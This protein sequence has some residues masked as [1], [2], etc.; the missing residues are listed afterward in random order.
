MKMSSKP[1]IFIFP[2]HIP[3]V[4]T[5]LQHYL[6]ETPN[7][8]GHTLNHCGYEVFRT[9]FLLAT[10]MILLAAILSFKSSTKRLHTTSGIICKRDSSEVKEIGQNTKLPENRLF[11]DAQ[12]HPLERSVYNRTST[13][14]RQHRPLHR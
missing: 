1:L 3:R 5:P 14:R 9:G 8:S 12:P 10:Q 4:D 6:L 13:W 2:M 7:R 11:L